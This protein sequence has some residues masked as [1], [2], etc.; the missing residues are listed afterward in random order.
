VDTSALFAP[1]ARTDRQALAARFQFLETELNA[2]LLEQ[3]QDADGLYILLCGEVQSG[4]GQLQPGD[5]FGETSLLTDRPAPFTVRCTTR[6]WVLKLDRTTFRE[7]I[8]T[9]PQVLAHVAEVASR[10]PVTGRPDGQLP[11]V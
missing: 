6:C 11:L 3:G 9:H 10:R 1:F 4:S 5:V 7:V 2:V 8:M